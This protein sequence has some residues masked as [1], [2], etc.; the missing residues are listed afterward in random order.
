[1]TENYI[2]NKVTVAFQ[3]FCPIVSL[4]NKLIT[5]LRGRSVSLGWDLPHTWSQTLQSMD[6]RGKLGKG[7]EE[8][9]EH[10]LSCKS[11]IIPYQTK[12]VSDA[13]FIL[14][15]KTDLKGIWGFLKSWQSQANLMS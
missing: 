14:Y 9:G 12:L 10:R 4:L 15:V 11:D 1:M 13:I 3:W 6:V 8:N 7:Y 2:V 5:I